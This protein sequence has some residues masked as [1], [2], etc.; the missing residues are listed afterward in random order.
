MESADAYMLWLHPWNPASDALVQQI[1][2]QD[3]RFRRSSKHPSL[4]WQ[5]K[6]LPA[7]RMHGLY[8][9]ALTVQAD[10]LLPDFACT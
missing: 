2:A 10:G 9:R 8:S 1:I 7:I 3:K 6:H 4:E 5:P